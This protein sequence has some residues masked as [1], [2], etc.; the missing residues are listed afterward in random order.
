MVTFRKT[1]A[2]QTYDVG[3]DVT[4]DTS[5]AQR[6]DGMRAMISVRPLRKVR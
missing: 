3:I 4:D 5:A 6:P 1:L 2:D